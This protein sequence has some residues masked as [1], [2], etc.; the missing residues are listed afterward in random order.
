ML[1][2]PATRGV[3]VPCPQI[4]GL[5]FRIIVLAAVEERIIAFAD[6]RRQ[7]TERIVSI[8]DFDGIVFDKLHHI[9]VGV[10][11]IDFTVR[12][13]RAVQPVEVNRAVRYTVLILVYN[14]HAIVYEI[15]CA[16]ADR[17][18][19][20]QSVR[21]VGISCGIRRICKPGL[22]PALVVGAGLVSGG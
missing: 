9:A 3:I 21:V 10:V 12:V 13:V 17:L 6:L 5:R 7:V 14:V 8:A 16:A 11:D 19:I 15:L 1:R 4:I 18:Y 22:L 2:E 20:P